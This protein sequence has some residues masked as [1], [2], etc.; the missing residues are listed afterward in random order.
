MSVFS[1]VA[2]SAVAAVPA[3]YSPADETVEAKILSERDNGLVME[4]TISCP[5]GVPGI[6]H[7]D[8]VGRVFTDARKVSHNSFARA[9]LETCGV[10]DTNVVSR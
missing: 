7:F 3:A 6:M 9:Y 2:A 5:Q 8:K 4:L 10:G 1:I